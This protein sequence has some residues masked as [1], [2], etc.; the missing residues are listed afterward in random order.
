MP[1][2]GR[3]PDVLLVYKKSKLSLYVHEKRNKRV[4]ELLERDAPIVSELKPA[5]DAHQ[6]T[7]AAVKEA[8]SER[9]VVF[10]TMYRARLRHADTT[11]KLIVTVGGD[12]TVLD[13]SHHIREATVLGVN[14]DPTRSVGFLCAANKDTFGDLLE[15]ALSRRLEPV[16]VR[17]IWGK[18]DDEPLPFPV[19]N[20]V[21][22]AHR[23]PAATVRYE[24]RT[25]GR[26][27]N[28][29]SSGVWIA[30]P[31]GTTA[32]IASAGGQVQPIA[33]DT[34][35]LLVR[36]PYVV[37]DMDHRLLKLRLAQED[38]VVL[39]SR[40]P[41]G[42][43]YFDGPH[44]SLPFGVGAALKLSLQGPPLSLLVTPEMRRRRERLE[45]R[46]HG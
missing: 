25:R 41:R 4:S 29:K 27:E 23:N 46:L 17:R 28:H 32:A 40:M 42:V 7:L 3:E 33:D 31:A 22:V 5:H 6:Q 30:A 13:A 2:S 37:D 18:L 19:L 35:Q 44:V 9:D 12:G 21:L 24:I 11:G 20:E 1:K 15:Q 38:E 39:R 45:E 10:K 14:S 34:W 16:S 26:T 36:E 8:L 43:V